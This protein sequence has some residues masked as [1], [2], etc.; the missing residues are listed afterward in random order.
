[1]LERAAEL[2]G[3]WRD[4]VYPGAACDVPS[5]LYCY[6]FEPKPDWSRR[7]AHQPEIL[8]Y[9]QHCARKYELTPHLRF[10][11]EVT[12]VEWDRTRDQWQVGVAGGDTVHADVVVCATGQ[13]SRPYVPELEGAAE[14]AGRQLHSARWD[15]TLDVGGQDIAVIGTGASAI[16]IIPELASRARRLTVLQRSAP[17]VVPRHDR[18]YAQATQRLFAASPAA[19]QAYRRLI[20]W[21]L[22]ARVLATVRPTAL[23]RL[24]ER[25]AKRELRLRVADPGLRDKLTPDYRLGCKRVLISDDYWAAM[26]T[27]GV[28]LETRAIERLVPEGI[29]VSGGDVVPA[30][31]LVYATGFRST[32]FLTPMR[33][34]GRD[35]SELSRVWKQG[36]SAYLG[37]SVPGFPNFFMLYGP[38]T[39]LGHSSILFMI[40]CQTNYVLACIRAMAEGSVGTLDVRATAAARDAEEIQAA[41]QHSLWTSGCHNWYRS[42]SG[43]QTN[44]WPYSTLRYWWCTQRVELADYH[45]EPWQAR[46]AQGSV[47]A[48][49]EPAGGEG[50]RGG[51]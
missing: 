5:F 36:A 1:V 17:W 29:R 46:A 9:A 47:S 35:G 19:M 18:R 41:S 33:V 39:N 27:P 4:N 32:E 2:G 3:V 31:V 26:Q 25:A 42:E 38:N 10:N 45:V 12:T 24:V 51:R 37:L 20:Y 23:T 44:N 13:L 40:E 8:R 50:R 16:Q 48:L 49:V 21:G 28:H 15:P 43:R 11:S 30:S 7:Y 34:V 6:S 14:F 22:E